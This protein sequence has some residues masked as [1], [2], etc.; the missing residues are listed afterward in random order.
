[1]NEYLLLFRGGETDRKEQTAEQ[2]Q[3][4]MYRWVQWMNGLQQQGLLLGAQPLSSTGKQVTGNRKAVVDGPYVQAGEAVAGYL[5]CRA[6][7]YNEA[8]GIAN[9][10]PILEFENGKVEV[11]EI[12]ELKM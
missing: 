9:G 12:Q 6:G 11:R 1:M 5:M 2:W 7:S 3:A 4:H 10:C 8:V